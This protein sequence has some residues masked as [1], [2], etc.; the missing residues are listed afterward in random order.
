MIQGKTLAQVV[1]EQLT[2]L[3]TA[4]PQ[5]SWSSERKAEYR[6]ALLEVGDSQAIVAGVTKA[7]RGWGGNY[8]PGVANLLEIVRSEVERIRP[9]SRQPDLPATPAWWARL[10]QGTLYASMERRGE[11]RSWGK[12]EPYVD[13]ARRHELRPDDFLWGLG[14]EHRFT[15]RDDRGDPL[16]GMSPDSHSDRVAEAVDEARILGA[17]FDEGEA[18]GAILAEMVGTSLRV[19]E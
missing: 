1:G 15:A 16:D 13:I 11:H 6:A 17:R 10:I 7:I 12:A 4:W 14:N 9:V 8:P 18:D 19:A 5:A 2:R 3:S